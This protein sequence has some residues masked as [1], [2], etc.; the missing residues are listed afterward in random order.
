[1]MIPGKCRITVP[2]IILLAV[3]SGWVLAAERSVQETVRLSIPAEVS[4]EEAYAMIRTKAGGACAS[5]AIYA[6]QQRV[7]RKA[8]ER[9]F[10]ADAVAAFD[11]RALTALHLERTGGPA[12][13]LAEAGTE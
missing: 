12:R 6:H 8:C 1:M 2:V 3:S 7:R 4:A 10:V 11:R 9:E 5:R 13:Q